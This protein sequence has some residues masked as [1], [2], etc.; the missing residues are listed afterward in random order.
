[1][2][3]PDWVTPTATVSASVIT[4]TRVSSNTA[5]VPSV[6][7]LVPAAIVT[8]GRSSSVIVSVCAAG[9]F[10][11]ALFDTVP[12]TVTVLSAASTSLFS[13]VTVTN[14]VLTV[15]LA[16]NVSTGLSLNVK[17]PAGVADT[18]TVNGVPAAS[19][20]VAVTT[21]TDSSLSLVA[22]SSCSAIVC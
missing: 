21:D 3:V 5:L 22:V 18:V 16:S 20:T 4:P 15:A 1:M 19:G 2:K 7:G 8:F 6:T 13:A 17:S 10:A 12:D 11:T 14:P 9:A